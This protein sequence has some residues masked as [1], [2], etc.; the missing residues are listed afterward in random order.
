M[1]DSRILND[2]VVEGSELGR[3]EHWEEA[4]KLELQN[5]TETGD[6]GELW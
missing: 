6:E 1:A 5:L 2:E 4:Y 3:R